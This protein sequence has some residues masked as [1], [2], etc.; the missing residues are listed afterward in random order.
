MVLGVKLWAFAHLLANGNLVHVI[1]F[2]SFLIWGVFS[3]KAARGRDKALATPYPAGTAS[4][5]ALTVVLGALAWAV[6]AFWA[7]GAWIGVR[8]LG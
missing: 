7:H 6:F 8:P 1:L 3:F 4:G 2:G 5:T